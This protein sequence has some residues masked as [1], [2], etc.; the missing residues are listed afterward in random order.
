MQLSRLF[1]RIA[2]LFAPLALLS[3]TWLYFYPS[4]D[5]RCA[6]P[7][8]PATHAHAT[9]PFRLLALG[10]PQLEGDSSLPDPHARIFPSVEDL[11]PHLRNATTL[12]ETRSIVTEAV[13]GVG[14]DAMRWLEGKRKAVD[15]WGNDWY[16]AH[17]VRTLR[18]W[19][20]PTHVSVLGDLLGSQWV[21]DG[22]FEKRAGRYWNV[23]MRGLEKV[24]DYIFGVEEIDRRGGAR[25]ETVRDD[26]ST[27]DEVE[28]EDQRKA[29][30][31]EQ[32]KSDGEEHRT[33]EEGEQSKPER[34]PAWGGTTEVL[35]ADKS[36]EK[37]IINIAGNHDVG[38][39][40]DI[41]ESRI[42]RFEK[43]FGS[44]NWDIWFTLPDG[45][46]SATATEDSTT[47]DPPPALRLVILN[48]MNLDTP[49]W[50][51][52]L[53]TETYSFMNHIIAN[54][55]SITDKTHATILLTHIPFEKESGI[56]VDSPF[57]DFFEDG[58][59][60][61]EQ[62][63]LSDHAGKII[64]EGIF[65]MSENRYAA[66]GGLGRTGIVVNGH[67]HEGCDVLHWIR[68]TGVEGGC[69]ADSIKREEAYW[70]AVA[71]TLNDSMPIPSADVD[72]I[73]VDAVSL[74]ETEPATTS[75][76]E[77]SETA[78][79]EPSTEPTAESPEPDASPKWKARRFPPLRYDINEKNECTTINDAPHIREIT[80][81]SMMGEFSGYAGFLSAWF[82][83][84][85]GDKGEWV[86]G[87]ASCGVG[88]QHWWWGIHILDLV[89]LVLFVIAGVL[90][91]V[92]SFLQEGQLRKEKEIREKEKVGVIR[93]TKTTADQ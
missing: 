71:V 77:A 58:Q 3:T 1:F 34:K 87:F 67:D 62:N 46:A 18:W 31:G 74:N 39:A 61:K 19:T 92:E 38:Y 56:C 37:R 83:P 32:S 82:D 16:L 53:Q 89:L 17:I 25:D 81:R 51:E 5:H 75:S 65:G 33:A 52:E 91:I 40:G 4:F 23:V 10:D 30:E 29:E 79:S 59:G 27:E 68:Q 88:V 84:S 76:D 43:A 72:D 26:A 44:V 9:A 47:T 66:G 21:T 86:F 64:L 85:M 57:F 41:D 55:R 20:E 14:K 15:L 13:N 50:S 73:D 42:E 49:A 22:E 45:Y 24:P 7:S 60:V 11:V 12:D 28:V 70:P 80:L 48:S 90:R 36:W 93:K 54:S 6:F 8:P 63:M 78:S 35:G 2:L 69:Q